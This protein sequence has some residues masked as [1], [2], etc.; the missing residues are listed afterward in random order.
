M[1][2]LSLKTSALNLK[3]GHNSIMSKECFLVEVN[4]GKCNQALLTKL[5]LCRLT[6]KRQNNRSSMVS[7]RAD[8]WLLHMLSKLAANKG[9]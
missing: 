2:V 8:V 1:A 6:E 3:Q 4:D 9:K 7:Q 5:R